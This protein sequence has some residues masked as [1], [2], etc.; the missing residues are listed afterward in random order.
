MK[1]TPRQSPLAVVSM[2][3]VLEKEHN[4][5]ISYQ[6]FTLKLNSR[7]SLPSFRLFVS[8]SVRNKE[9]SVSKHYFYKNVLLLRKY[10]YL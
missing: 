8:N 6:P 10:I 9:M 7:S 2:I 3:M 4:A 5:F 1:T